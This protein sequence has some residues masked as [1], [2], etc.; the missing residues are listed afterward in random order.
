MLHL[1]KKVPKKLAKKVKVIETLEIILIKQEIDK[2]RSRYC[3]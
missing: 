3:M 2:R 1:W